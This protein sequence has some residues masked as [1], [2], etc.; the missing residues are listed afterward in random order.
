MVFSVTL[1]CVRNCNVENK[2]SCTRLYQLSVCFITFASST[3]SESNGNSA[4]WEENRFYFSYYTDFV[5]DC[6]YFDCYSA[7]EGPTINPLLVIIYIYSMY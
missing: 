2:I 5:L 6:L 3:I 4:K 1:I 7:N